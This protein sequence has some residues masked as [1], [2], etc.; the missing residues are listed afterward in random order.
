MVQAAAWKKMAGPLGRVWA[1]SEDGHRCTSTGCGVSGW[2]DYTV[3]CSD[4]CRIRHEYANF[5]VEVLNY[6]P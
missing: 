5:F 1:L 2:D 3:F 6:L 4:D